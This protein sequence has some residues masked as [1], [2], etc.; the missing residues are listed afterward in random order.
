MKSKS[1]YLKVLLLFIGILILLNILASRHYLRLD[2]TEDK[3]YTLGASTKEILKDLPEP[4]T[5][6]AYFSGN[7]PPMLDNLRRDLRDL[8]SEYVSVSKGMVA[9]EFIDPLKEPALEEKA[10]QEGVSTVD[11]GVRE[12]DKYTQQKAFMGAVVQVGEQS[13]AIPVIQSSSGLEYSLTTAI[14]KLSVKEKPPVG[15]LQGHGEPSVNA[16]VQARQS[17]NILYQLEDVYLNDTTDAL[18]KYNTL[19]IIGPTDSIP[20]G[21]LSQIDEFLKRGGSLLIAMNRVNADL[22]NSPM[23]IEITTG[24]ESWLAKKGIHVENSFALDINCQ[25]IQFGI[26]RGS[27]TEIRSAVFPYIF[28]AKDFSKHVVSGGLEQVL[29]KFASPI[30]FS[31][32]SMVKFTPLIKTSA[33]STTEQAQTYFNLER[34]WKEQ[35]FPMSGLTVAAA[36]EGPFNGGSPAKMIVIGDADFPLSQQGQQAIPDNI[37]LFVNSIDW[38]TDQTGLVSLR[39]KGATARPL[40]ELTDGKRSFLKFLNFFLPLFF[41]VGYGIFR[42]QKNR[43]KRLK[44]KEVGYV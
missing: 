34:Q 2:I 32:D 19:A 33:K 12:N 18:L 40:D 41:V 7:L 42:F 24:L 4:V 13:E 5:I 27:F 43:I 22:N 3:R 38:L 1:T 26:Q 20:P 6:T 30:S 23:G 10:K 14:K 21:H 44:R 36:V 25:V 11:I 28:A 17:L 16:M 9:Y 31:G 37:S 35:D 8:L 29:F 39:T 15:F